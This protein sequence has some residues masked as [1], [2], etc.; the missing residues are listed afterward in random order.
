MPSYIL[1]ET[2]TLQVMTGNKVKINLAF[3]FGLI[4]YEF[5]LKQNQNV[6]LWVLYGW[7]FAWKGNCHNLYTVIGV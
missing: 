6:R 1:W 7:V 2:V 5:D 4:L 3:D